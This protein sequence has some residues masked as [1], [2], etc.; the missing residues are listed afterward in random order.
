MMQVPPRRALAALGAV[1]AIG[2][3]AGL[4]MDGSGTACTE[5]GCFPPDNGTGTVDC[6]SC[7]SED[8]VFVLGVVNVV[9]HC[10]GTERLRFEDGTRVERRVV[11][12]ACGYRL[13]V[14]G[15]FQ[16]PVQGQKTVSSRG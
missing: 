7:F 8:P 12:D 10:D 2:F 11:W 1:I 16:L 15:G 9:E 13:R 14:M 3:V 4:A 6:N 5:M